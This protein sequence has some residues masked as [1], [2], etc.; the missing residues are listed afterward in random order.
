MQFKI[1]DVKAEKAP[2]ATMMTIRA[3]QERVF[4]ASWPFVL[5]FRYF[6]DWLSAFGLRPSGFGFRAVN[7]CVPSLV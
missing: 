3:N 2:L 4:H 7:P 5:P 1:E 6:C